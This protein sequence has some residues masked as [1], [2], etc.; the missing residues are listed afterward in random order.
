MLG[1]NPSALEGGF[2]PEKSDVLK[3][4]LT[5]DA[6]EKIKDMIVAGEL[7]PGDRL[8]KEPD[9][10]LR[11]GLSRNSL[12]EAVR[13]LT[14]MKVLDVRQGDGTYVTSLEPEL[15]L[16]AMRFVRDFHRD[17]T[18][19]E[20]LEVRRLLEPASVALATLRMTDDDI[21]ELKTILDRGTINTPLEQFIR[22]DTEFHRR[23]AQGA[24]NQ[25]LVSILDG[26]V[27]PTT[28]TRILRGLTEEGALA[29]SIS[30]HHMIYE[31]VATRNPELARSW[32]TVHICGVEHWMRREP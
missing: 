17:E 8:P 6:I 22:A 32:A 7:K 28:R 18:I 10:A 14:F 4:A 25:A 20:L 24:G 31:G 1:H 16:D 2:W 23:L 27:A 9:L 21:K 5:D 30:E 15:L 11:L 12:R 26:L 13:A 19:L 3:M 29:R